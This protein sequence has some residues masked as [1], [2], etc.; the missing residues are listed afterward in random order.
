MAINSKVGP[1]KELI[2]LLRDS[3]PEVVIDGDD[4]YVARR[5]S[6]SVESGPSYN[7]YIVVTYQVRLYET[8]LQ[9]PSRFHTQPLHKD[10]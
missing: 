6:V 8:H 10:Q 4:K 5:L 9:P 1:N 3:T 7:R 2:E